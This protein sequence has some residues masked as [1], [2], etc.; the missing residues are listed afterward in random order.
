MISPIDRRFE[1]NGLSLHYRDW[2][3][4]GRP[5]VLLHGLAST[6]HIW[7][8]VAP[9]LAGEFAVLAL[10]QRGHGQSDRP[11][12]GYD[13]ETVI[14]DLHSLISELG[15]ER[16]IIV[17]HSWGGD[18]AMEYAVAYPEVAGGLA[19]IDGGLIEFSNRPGMSLSRAK[20]ELAPPVFNGVTVDELR[21]RARSWP[22]GSQMSTQLEAILMANFDVLE[23][24]TIRARLAR[25]N[26]MQI[27]EALWGH[28]PSMLCPRVECP[29]LI[30]PARQKDKE[31]SMARRFNREEAVARAEK[32]LPRSET[33]WLEDSIHDVP[34][35][36]PE[37]VADI[38]KGRA[39]ASFFG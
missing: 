32:L 19:L 7:D 14:G 25:D 9:L 6:C 16:P 1:K 26:H 15:L 3:G 17:G 8:L 34:L 39:K 36:R 29:V 4:P 5:V 27:I 2:G 33:V 20:E 35:Q 28:S 18:V 13:F 23:D 38:I 31:S 12:H 11:D 22:L 21:A 30:M 10:D 24:G 37:L